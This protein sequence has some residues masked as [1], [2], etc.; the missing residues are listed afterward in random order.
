MLTSGMRNSLITLA[1]SQVK[2]VYSYSKLQPSCWPPYLL[3]KYLS[4]IALNYRM[5]CLTCQ[6]FKRIIMHCLLT[7]KKRK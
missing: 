2:G 5:A 4:V 1:Y 6:A 3:P 7:Q